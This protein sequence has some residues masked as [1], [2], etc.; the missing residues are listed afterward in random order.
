MPSNQHRCLAAIVWLAV[1]LTSDHLG[2]GCQAGQL[3]CQT[4]VD[5]LDVSYTAA[6][7]APCQGSSQVRHQVLLMMALKAS[8]QPALPTTPISPMRQYLHTAAGAGHWKDIRQPSSPRPS[9]WMGTQP[10][11]LQYWEVAAGAVA[12]RTAQHTSAHLWRQHH[13]SLTAALA[14]LVREQPKS[15]LATLGRQGRQP[16]RQQLRGT[17]VSA[18]CPGAQPCPPKLEGPCSARPA[19]CEGAACAI[20]KSSP[21]HL[22]RL[23]EAAAP[24]GW[25]LPLPP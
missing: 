12:H 1:W 18:V 20:G 4:A 14:G 6:Q 16:G 5:A 25:G 2:A 13:C 3:R 17:A 15:R 9:G 24:A 10:G 23:W 19:W 11:K 21:A 8:L 7:L 22:Q